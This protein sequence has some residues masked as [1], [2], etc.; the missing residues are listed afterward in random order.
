[1]SSVQSISIV[2]L[3]FLIQTVSSIVFYLIVARTLPVQEVCAITLFF[4]FGGILTVA[5][6]LN[7]DTA[8]THF[9]SYF[10]GKTGTYSLPRFFLVITAIIMVI[11]FAA[12]ASVSHVIALAF[13]HSSSYSAVIILMDGYVSASVG[14]GYMVSI[15]REFS[16]SEWL[17]YQIYC[18]QSFQWVFLSV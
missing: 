9:I 5:F 6:S 3:S 15:L 1:M 10:M 16:P 18:I 11:S 7:L 4:S 2:S 8:F 17:P 14:L 13:F 12:I